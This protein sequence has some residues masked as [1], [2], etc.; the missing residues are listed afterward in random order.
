MANHEA[1][2]S[3]EA[4]QFG[5]PNVRLEVQDFG[6]LVQASVELRPLTVFVGPSNTGKTYLALLIYALHYIFAGF[7]RLPLPVR[8]YM[9]FD[10]PPGYWKPLGIARETLEEMLESLTQRKQIR[11]SELPNVVYQEL[12]NINKPESFGS[13]LLVRLWRC[14]DVELNPELRK[15]WE[16]GRG[17]VIMKGATLDLHEQ[18]LSTWLQRF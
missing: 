4:L 16:M 18:R 1:A 8:R 12:V 17:C 6:P 3:S 9:D 5:Q 7:P 10:M 11:L 14:F 2:T 13:D 15:T